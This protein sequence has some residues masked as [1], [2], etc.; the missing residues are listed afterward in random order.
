MVSTQKRPTPASHTQTKIKKRKIEKHQRKANQKKFLY[1]NKKQ[2]Y[3]ALALF[4]IAIIA[5]GGIYAYQSRKAAASTVAWGD[6]VKFNFISYFDNGEVIQHTIAMNVSDVTPETSLDDGKL[7]IPQ[8]LTTGGFKEVSGILTPLYWNDDVFIDMKKGT[9]YTISIPAEFALGEEYSLLT[10]E[11]ARAYS[12]PRA[13]EFISGNSIGAETFAEEY[14][15]PSIGMEFEAEG[16]P[17][18]VT[19]M[20]DTTVTYRFNYAEGDSVDLEYGPAIV[21]GIEEDTIYAEYSGATEDT[22]Y[23]LFERAYL[24]VHITAVTE[25]ELAVEI[26]HYNYKIRVEDIEKSSI[27]TDDWTI[28][29]GDYALVRYIGYYEDGEVF[30]SSIADDVDLTPDLPLDNTYRNNELQV[31]VTPGTK[32]TGTQTL[33]AGFN[34]ALKGMVAGDEK[35]I[36]VLPEDGYGEWDPE[37]VKTLDYAIG[38]Y[39]LEETLSKTITMSIEDFT[40]EYVQQPL[41]NNTIELDYGIGLISS[42]AG[43]TVTIDVVSL[44]DGEFYMDYFT[45]KVIAEDDETFTIQRLVEDGDDVPIPTIGGVAVASVADGIVT[46]AYDPSDIVL[47]GTMGS[48]TITRVGETSFDVDYNHAMAGKTLLFK[49][50]V[51]A[52]KKV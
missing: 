33:I 35:V 37:K 21:T 31:T 4:L 1:R 10:P 47:D 34:D 44:D 39:Q 40:L 30:D 46:V 45:T 43:E 32:I 41:E 48:G 19:E 5:V 7:T 38:T 17:A 9:T 29:D 25:D 3:T 13:T 52:F 8:R 6:E 51:V 22:L 28:S 26:D 24:P 50:H 20:D 27:D 14:G 23:V 49:I 15:E 36:T 2:I 18:I 12:V 11:E 42:V 16:R